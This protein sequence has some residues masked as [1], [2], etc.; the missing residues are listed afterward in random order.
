MVKATAT[1]Y[2]PIPSGIYKGKLVGVDE[3]T[4]DTGSYWAWQF[5]LLEDMEGDPVEPEFERF[6]AISSTNFMP[7]SK[8]RSW[9]NNMIGRVLADD[10]EIDFDETIVGKHYVLTIAISPSGRNTLE[11]VSPAKRAK[12]ATPAPVRHIPGYPTDDD[13]EDE[14]VPFN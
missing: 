13:E 1:A 3:K 14:G 7:K 9:V 8:A 10:E 6:N 12:Q 4:N 5:Y 2:K 11:A